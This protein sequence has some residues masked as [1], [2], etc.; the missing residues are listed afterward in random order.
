MNINYLTTSAVTN[1]THKLPKLF[2][3]LKVKKKN[4]FVAETFP[5][6]ISKER[7]K[8]IYKLQSDKVCTYFF[9]PP[10][11]TVKFEY[12]RSCIWGGVEVC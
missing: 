1:K 2:S 8:I 10:E 3:S 4:F 6:H 12:F 11:T 7:M 9:R 5:R